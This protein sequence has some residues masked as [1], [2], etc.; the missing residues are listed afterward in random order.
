MYMP[1]G[2][3]REPSQAVLKA[4]ERCPAECTVRF[5]LHAIPRDMSHMD[6]AARCLSCMTYWEVN[7][8]GTITTLRVGADVPADHPLRDKSGTSGD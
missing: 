7:R 3:K 4:L 8:D 1:N 2:Q 5:V 6:A